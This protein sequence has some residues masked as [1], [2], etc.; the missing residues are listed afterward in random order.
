MNHV[1]R[2]SLVLLASFLLT[3]VGA[4]AASRSSIRKEPV[5]QVHSASITCRE[6]TKPLT[7]VLVNSQAGIAFDRS[8]IAGGGGTSSGMTGAGV[9]ITVD[10]TVGQSATGTTS[11]SSD[12]QFTVTG[13]FWQAEA[14]P[15]PT[16]TPIPTPTPTPTPTPNPA[17]PVVF[18]EEGTVNRALALNSVTQVRGPFSVLT[19]HNF[20]ADH[21]TRVILFT[22]NLGMNQ[23][24]SSILTVQAAGFPL[25]VENVGTVL[26]VTGLNASYII[27]RLPDGLPPGDLPLLIIL[28]GVS[29]SN[30]PTISI[31]P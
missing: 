7:T 4:W 17:A 15:T 20:S 10:G 18:I 11:N 2:K 27:V 23:P 22:T 9:T 29:S 30:S 25:L 21:H 13:G 6:P 1:R 12:G 3:L 8:V 28:R 24:D 16:P 19:D 31:S 26:G 14:T 5:K